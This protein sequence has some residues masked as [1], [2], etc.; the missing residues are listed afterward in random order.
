MAWTYYPTETDPEYYGLNPGENRS[1]SIGDAFIL[2]YQTKGPMRPGA[3]VYWSQLSGPTQTT[4][5]NPNTAITNVSNFTL[6]EYKF[7]LRA[8]L[9]NRVRVFVDLTITVIDPPPPVVLTKRKNLIFRFL[10]MIPGK[11]PFAVRANRFLLDGK[12]SCEFLAAK[13]YQL[14]LPS[15]HRQCYNTGQMLL[16]LAYVLTLNLLLHSL[17][18]YGGC[19]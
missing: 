14:Q 17:L 6:G 9:D 1:Q 18:T 3:P 19:Q 8:T 13:L 12:K 16:N 2:T 10:K 15:H 5:D 7:R 11:K 4:M